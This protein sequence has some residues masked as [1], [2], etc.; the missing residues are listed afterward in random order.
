MTRIAERK[1]RMVAET[2]AVWRGDPLIVTIEPHNVVIRAKGRRQAYTVPWLG[3][4]ELGQKLTAIET[5]K[6]KADA[7]RS[8]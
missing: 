2:S 5:R 6:Q 4:Y 7:R 1:T 8:R 3:I